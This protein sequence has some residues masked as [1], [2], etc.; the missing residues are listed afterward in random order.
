MNLKILTLLIILELFSTAAIAYVRVR[1]FNYNNNAAVVIHRN[2]DGG[3]IQRNPNINPAN[4]WQIR[5]NRDYFREEPDIFDD[6]FN[7]GL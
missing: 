7:N 1:D 3:I 2:N 5:D 4:N 6:E